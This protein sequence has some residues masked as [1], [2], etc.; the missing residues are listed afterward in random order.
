MS[1]IDETYELIGQLSGGILGL[2]PSAVMRES[3]TNLLKSQGNSNPSESEVDEV[4]KVWT[5]NPDGSKKSDVENYYKV[6]ICELEGKFTIIK[7]TLS[8]VPTEFAAIGATAASGFAASAA[9]PMY[10]SIKTEVANAKAQLVECLKL[11]CEM[12]IGAPSALTSIVSTL[13][14]CA[15]LVGL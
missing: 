11:C 4:V 2:S 7:N 6:K 5:E 13:T 8:Q 3:A 14:Q 1:T 9:V 12:G 15:S 10:L